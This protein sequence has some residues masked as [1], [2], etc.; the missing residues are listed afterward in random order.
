MS[1]RPR[2]VCAFIVFGNWSER[3]DRVLRPGGVKKDELARGAPEALLRRHACACTSYLGACHTTPQSWARCSRVPVC[4]RK[5]KLPNSRSHFLTKRIYLES[6]LRANRRDG[7]PGLL[8][9]PSFNSVSPLQKL[10]PGPVRSIFLR[11]I[12][13][14]KRCASIC[15]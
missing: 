6:I 15:A 11:V 5:Q 1:L 7:C 14:L 12:T 9:P 3:P 2:F 10:N 13:R 8:R 4:L